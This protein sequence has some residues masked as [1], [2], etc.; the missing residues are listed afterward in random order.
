[1]HLL[2]DTLKETRRGRQDVH[3]LIDLLS[4]SVFNNQRPQHNNSRSALRNGL[5][6]FIS[7]LTVLLHLADVTWW[8]FWTLMAVPPVCRSL[9][10]HVSL[11]CRFL[12]CDFSFWF[13]LHVCGHHR[14]LGTGNTQ[15]KLKVYRM[16]QTEERK[17]KVF[18]LQLYNFHLCLTWIQ[19]IY[20]MAS[21]NTSATYIYL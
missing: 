17:K 8:F 1:M 20:L 5:L 3:T 14:F 11:S 9:P 7:F 6:H 2:I 12:T 16:N 15:L 13:I 4:I 21:M 10:V 19:S 18:E